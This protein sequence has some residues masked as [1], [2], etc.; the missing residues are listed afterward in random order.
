MVVHV[1]SLTHPYLLFPSPLPYP[2]LT[3]SCCTP[4]PS[5]TVSSGNLR[6][7]E[8]SCVWIGSE[9]NPCRGTRRLGGPG[10]GGRTS[11]PVESK[12]NGEGPETLGK[13]KDS[14]GVWEV[15]VEEGVQQKTP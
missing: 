4:T 5:T 8:S 6:D 11:S 2:P 12:E 14:D 7:K 9:A 13:G 15:E 3:P 1:F 10:P